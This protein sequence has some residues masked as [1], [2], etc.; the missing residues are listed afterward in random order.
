MSMVVLL[1]TA[2]FNT[3]AEFVSCDYD[4]NDHDDGNDDFDDGNHDF[5]DGY[6]DS[7]DGKAMMIMMMVTLMGVRYLSVLMQDPHCS[8]SVFAYLC[9]P[10]H[11]L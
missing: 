9:I 8:I 6:D 4:N 1:V 7:D 5:D 10:P 2:L 11:I 3:L